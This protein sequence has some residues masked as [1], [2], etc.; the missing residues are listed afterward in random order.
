MEAFNVDTS[1]V[2]PSDL[3]KLGNTHHCSCCVGSSTHPDE[4]I[5]I[6]QGTEIDLHCAFC[7]FHPDP[8]A[9]ILAVNERDRTKCALDMSQNELPDEDFMV[10]LQRGIKRKVL[11]VSL[12]TPAEQKRQ[13]QQRMHDVLSAPITYNSPPGGSLAQKLERSIR[14]AIN[15][16]IVQAE[17]NKREIFTKNWVPTPD[18]IWAGIYQG[19]RRKQMQAALKKA[20]PRVIE[21]QMQGHYADETYWDCVR[22]NAEFEDMMGARH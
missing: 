10:A 17:K 21:M 14:D 16:S 1:Y 4:S 19:F 22:A 15:R 13:R 9:Q 2:K 7:S 11:E 5:P 20:T 3:N 6:C 8:L 12:E 18:H